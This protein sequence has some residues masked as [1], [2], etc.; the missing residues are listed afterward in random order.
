M[1]RIISRANWSFTTH[2]TP[3][4]LIVPNRMTADAAK[5]LTAQGLCSKPT[6]PAID[7]PNPK[8]LRAHPTA[9]PKQYSKPSEPPNREPN[10]LAIKK[11]TPPVST[12]IRS[13]IPIADNTLTSAIPTEQIITIIEWSI[14]AC[15]TI[16]PDRRN[17]ITPK[18]F[19]I[20]VVKTPSHFPNNVGCEIKKCVR[21]LQ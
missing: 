13:T 18:M 1:R 16:Q 6:S 14:P 21:H 5:A 12:R 15:A 7:S 8:T 10:V 4:T 19:T 11:Y 20:V 2:F 17:T 3:A 9:W